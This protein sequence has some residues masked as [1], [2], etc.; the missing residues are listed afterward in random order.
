MKN[1]KSA[2]SLVEIMVAL[3]IAA[4][5]IVPI[6]TVFS[7]SNKQ[8]TRGHNFTFASSLARRLI[9]HVQQQAFNKIQDVPLPG[10]LIGG[11]KNDFY[12][13]QLINLGDSAS[14]IKYLTET[15]SPDLYK[16]IRKYAF[17]YSIS[18]GAVNFAE[19]DKVKSV[20]V[21]I[22]WKE[23]GKDYLYTSHVFVSSY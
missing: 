2:T 10:E 19:E 5:V 23:M 16:F 6:S 17:R 3:S 7:T 22:T 4:M 13:G 21:Y 12:F 1:N 18:V 20:S 14:T 9:Q 11:N 15:D 8:T